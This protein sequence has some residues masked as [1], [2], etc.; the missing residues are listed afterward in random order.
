MPL[1][2]TQAQLEALAQ[3]VAGFLP[4]SLFVV[5]SHAKGTADRWSDLDLYAVYDDAKHPA[6]S[7]EHVFWLWEG[8]WVSAGVLSRS[9]VEAELETPESAIQAIPA[10]RGMEIVRD[11]DGWAAG[12]RQRAIDFRWADIKAEADQWVTGELLSLCEE[13]GKGLRAL[14][15]RDDELALLVCIGLAFP[16]TRLAA[17]IRGILVDSDNSYVAQVR[18]VMGAEWTAL[19][20]RVWGDDLL[21][22]LER[23]RAALR[24][25]LVLLDMHQAPDREAAMLAENRRR[26]EAAL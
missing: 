7:R 21:P 8:V 20:R 3:E 12:L 15:N 26:L 2:L 11:E 5:G 25:Y 22:P 16:L 17:M 19:H 14:E 13:C 1:P 24:L 18:E 9:H 4:E 23:L 10:Y 6:P